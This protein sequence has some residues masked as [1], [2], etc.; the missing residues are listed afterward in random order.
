[1]LDPF[2]RWKGQMTEKGLLSILLGPLFVVMSFVVL[3]AV[4][5][6]GGCGEL[7]KVIDAFLPAYLWFLAWDFESRS[8]CIANTSLIHWIRL[9]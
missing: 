5:E 3:D 7:C 1:M 4:T 8:S 6:R 9:N 2:Y